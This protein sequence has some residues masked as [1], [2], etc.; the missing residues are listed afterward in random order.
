M[1]IIKTAI[2]NIEKIYF[3]KRDYQ[4]RI[5]IS[6]KKQSEIIRRKFIL[7]ALPPSLALLKGTEIEE[8]FIVSSSCRDLRLSR[9]NKSYFISLREKK[10]SLF[11][12]QEIKITKSHFESLWPFTEGRRIKRRSYLFQLNKRKVKV[13]CFLGEHVP[14]QIIEVFFPTLK[15]SR[16]FKKPHFFGEEVTSRPEYDVEA[17]A[18]HGFPEPPD[19]CQIGV[20]P[21]LI[22]GGKLQIL[23]ITSSSGNR[24]II[25]KGSQEKGMTPCEVAVMEAVEE[26]GVLGTLHQ[27]LRLR[28]QMLNGRFLKLYPMK[29]SKLL[30]SWPEERLRRRRLVSLAAALKLIDD[31]EIVSAVKRLGKEL[32]KRL[33]SN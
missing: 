4:H 31:P 8:G 21:Y 1:I 33:A 24:W 14:L 9:N 26:G 7:L 2:K 29:I 28:C 32:K 23:L 5:Q 19:I 6:M 12:S 17:M 11:H 18:L 15:A 3:Q 10:N 25:P 27:D 20:F 22:K 13:D 16:I 30:N